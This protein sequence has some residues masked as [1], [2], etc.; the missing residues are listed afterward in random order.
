MEE[1]L[2]KVVGL[3]QSF[4]MGDAK[5][6]VAGEKDREILLKR[7]RGHRHVKLLKR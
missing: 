3:A 1:G 4:E 7:W 2:E 5:Y 6:L